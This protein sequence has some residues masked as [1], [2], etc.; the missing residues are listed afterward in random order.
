MFG[1]GLERR[2]GVHCRLLPYIPSFLSVRHHGR[3]LFQSSEFFVHRFKKDTA[4][5]A[6]TTARTIAVLAENIRFRLTAAHLAGKVKLL[7]LLCVVPSHLLISDICQVY[8]RALLLYVRPR[9]GVVASGQI[10]L[11]LF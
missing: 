3:N 1:D 6:S 4:S 5:V 2:E 11:L 9:K 8:R 7:L 10:Y